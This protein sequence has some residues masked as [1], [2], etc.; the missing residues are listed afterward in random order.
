MV[1][2]KPPLPEDLIPYYWDLGVQHVIPT[3]HH[4]T[5]GSMSDMEFL[6]RSFVLEHRSHL[7]DVILRCV[8]LHGPAWLEVA[9]SETKEEFSSYAAKKRLTTYPQGHSDRSFP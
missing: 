8:Q 4:L 9:V 7:E 1:A 2:K 6:C 5:E 3:S